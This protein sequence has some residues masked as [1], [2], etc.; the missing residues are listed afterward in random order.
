[1]ITTNNVKYAHTPTV[2]LF[3]LS[4]VVNSTLAN[5][6]SF[7]FAQAASIP[8]PIPTVILIQGEGWLDA[9]YFNNFENKI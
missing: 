8:I 2:F 6:A 5:W 3:W 4:P 1:M 7:V 9:G